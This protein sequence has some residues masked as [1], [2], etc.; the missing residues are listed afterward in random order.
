MLDI[1]TFSPHV[2]SGT[3]NLIFSDPASLTLNF[4]KRRAAYVRTAPRIPASPPHHSDSA[5][6][7]CRRRAA[8]EHLPQAGDVGRR[9]AMSQFNL[10][11]RVLAGGAEGGTGGRSDAHADTEAVLSAGAGVSMPRRFRRA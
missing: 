8:Y 7:I 6:V 5:P 11:G 9:P 10:S 2:S 4:R 1:D 3:I